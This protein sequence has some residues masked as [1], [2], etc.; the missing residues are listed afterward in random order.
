MILKAANLSKVRM[1]KMKI[2]IAKNKKNRSPEKLLKKMKE[3]GSVLIVRKAI[4]LTLHFTLIAKL[5]TNRNGQ[6]LIQ[7]QSHQKKS[8]RTE[9]GRGYK[10]I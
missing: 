7:P 9:V 4:C 6:N 3:N 5:N 8:E 1:T 10:I 2:Q